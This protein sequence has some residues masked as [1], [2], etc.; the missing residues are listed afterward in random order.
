MVGMH[1]GDDHSQHRQALQLG[2]EYLLP[3]AAGC[4][5]G[6]AAVD[7]RPSL[8]TVDRIAQQPE[9][10][11]IE[12]ER[13]HHPQPAHAWRDLDRLAESR[14]GFAERVVQLHFEGV[15]RHR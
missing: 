8:D 14:Q 9:V 6:D 15:H 11:V 13:K 5:V 12:L 2:L 4:V 1:V 3:R 7:D 10:D